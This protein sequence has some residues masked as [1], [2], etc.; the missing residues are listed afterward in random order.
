MAP[1]SNITYLLSRSLPENLKHHLFA[2][3]VLIVLT[4]NITYLLSTTLTEF[5]QTSPI[6]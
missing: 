1:S 4:S 5:P 3:A 6:C 2:E